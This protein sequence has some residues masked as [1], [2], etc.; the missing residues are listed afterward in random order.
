MDRKPLPLRLTH[1]DYNQKNALFCYAKERLTN[2]SLVFKLSK[3]Q[4]TASQNKIVLSSRNRFCRINLTSTQTCH[5]QETKPFT[6]Q[7]KTIE[8]V[9]KLSLSLFTK[10]GFTHRIYRLFFS[11]QC[12]LTPLMT[13][14]FLIC[15][16]L[17]TAIK[18]VSISSRHYHNGKVIHS[19]KY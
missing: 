12:N 7:I 2:F 17:A 10:G 8:F 11:L 5:R 18:S 14:F 3:K 6:A 13:L 16:R 4:T 1:H 9:T 19:N 15:P